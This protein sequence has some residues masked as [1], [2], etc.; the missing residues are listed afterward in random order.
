MESVVLYSF[1]A[2][3]EKEL[4][5]HIIWFD[6]YVRH[7]VDDFPFPCV[8]GLI[9]I[10][11]ICFSRMSNSVTDFVYQ[12]DSDLYHCGSESLNQNNSTNNLENVCAYVFSLNTIN[13]LFSY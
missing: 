1:R 3:F 7:H 6:T 2:Q 4:K 12:I 5:E 8:F 11:K 13:C 10:C 9:C